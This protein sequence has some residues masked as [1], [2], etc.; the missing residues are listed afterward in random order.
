M[1]G[2]DRKRLTRVYTV[3]SEAY[4][5][6]LKGRFWWNKGTEEGFNKGIEYFQQ[7]IAKDPTYAQA[8][9][10]IADCYSSLAAGASFQQGTVI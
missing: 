2:E 9:S 5:D 4:E 1:T 10:G 6:Y 7:A 3:N 8:Y